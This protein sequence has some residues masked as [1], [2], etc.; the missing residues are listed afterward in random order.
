MLKIV[1]GKADQ[2]EERIISSIEEH[3]KRIK[4]A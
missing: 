2:V 3:A 1:S 4:L